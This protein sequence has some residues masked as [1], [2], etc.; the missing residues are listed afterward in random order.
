[1][2]EV[3]LD[4]YYFYTTIMDQ[5]SITKRQFREEQWRQRIM[6]CRSSGMS[7]KNWCE[8]NGLCE[9]TYYKYLKKFRQE[10]CDALPIPVQTPEKPVAFKKLEVMS[11][12]PD[13]KAAVIIRLPN[14][15]LEIN[16]GASQQTVQAVLLALQSIC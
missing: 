7:V 2:E 10:M 15:T 3:I 12:L 1:M 4:L 13:T 9:Q 8:S 11:P 16:E 5:V 14:A 6:E